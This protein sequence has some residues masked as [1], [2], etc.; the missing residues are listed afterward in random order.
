[1]T[2]TTLII[3]SIAAALLLTAA[4]A[5]AEPMDAFGDLD[6]GALM[7]GASGTWDLG[8]LDAVL[9]LDETDVTLHSD[10]S[11]TDRVHRIVWI[12]TELA[13]ETYG[14][15]RVPWNSDTSDFK[16]V[17][18][19]TW[20]GGKW[21]PDETEISET[22]VVP[23]IPSAVRSADDYTGMRETMLLHD[24][25]ELPCIVE[26]A[27]EITRRPWDAPAGGP[28]GATDRPGE[29]G[30]W[31]FTKS[32]P[33][34]IS[35]LVV[36]EPPGED[37]SFDSANGAPEPST[38][39]TGENGIRFVWEMRDLDRAPHPTVEDPPSVAPNV[40]WSTWSGWE[41]LGGAILSRFDDA[42]TLSE[43]LKDSV[44]SLVEREPVAWS[45]AKSVARFVAETTRP[46]RYPDSYWEFTPREA[47]RTWETAYGH[48][49]D[50]AV[51]AA[52]LFREAGCPALPLYVSNG[53][54]GTLSPELPSLSRYGGISLLVDAGGF[55]A[56][57]DPI[58]STLRPAS[59]VTADRVTWVPGRKP[60][61]ETPFG[62]PGTLQLTLTLEPSEDGWTGS[63][64]L[65]ARN[66]LSPHGSMMGLEDESE[67]ALRALA[68]SA[69]EGASVTGWSPL[70]F[71]PRSVVCG[72]SVNLASPEPDD[73]GRLRVR[74]A[75]PDAGIMGA[76]PPDVHLYV[77]HR[78]SP[79]MLPSALE[80]TL[81]LN[82]DPGDRDIV[83]KPEPLSMSNPAGS[84]DVAVSE[85]DDG[86]LSITRK[87]R[88][89]GG[90]ID[91]T[92]WTDL[93]SLLLAETNERNGTILL[94]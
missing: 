14:D 5:A 1:M 76:L 60:D 26:T 23:T 80:Q 55:E 78:D 90:T 71:K 83:A 2:G 61:E 28:G 3:A 81:T 10:G 8:S 93:R 69:L 11:R 89:N 62:A 58:T 59:E 37:L 33:C 67:A 9:L 20:R 45:R 52:A 29:Y 84:L 50:R 6:I 65:E 91:A 17:S 70:E 92:Q 36:T 44:S 40:V 13:L 7:D 15:L 19:R 54:T 94:R 42:S 86:T 74:L 87:L 32:D 35:R 63:A 77:A 18:L 82:I 47:D 73:S 25:I 31:T 68:S 12:A 41:Q 38:T 22:A 49:L 66:A 72:F 27:Y 39:R 53:L 16:V 4:P 88:L 24:G 34:V 48:R 43:A 75:S 30:M 56:V 64:A 79:V 85:N 51:L 46:V 57:Y 21:W